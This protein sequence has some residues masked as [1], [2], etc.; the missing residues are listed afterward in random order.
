MTD[1]HRNVYEKFSAVSYEYSTVGHPLQLIEISGNVVPAA[2]TVT[3]S[4]T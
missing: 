3:Y 2:R 4:A 1:F